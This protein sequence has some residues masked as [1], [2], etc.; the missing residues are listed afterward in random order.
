MTPDEAVMVLQDD[1][2]TGNFDTGTQEQAVRVLLAERERLLA[3]VQA[4]REA[5]RA[6]VHR[7]E[8]IQESES[9]LSAFAIAAVHGAPYRGESWTPELDAANAAL[10]QKARP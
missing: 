9:Y 2:G 5:L 1:V 8:V 10:A 6:L 4:L 3:E 7:I